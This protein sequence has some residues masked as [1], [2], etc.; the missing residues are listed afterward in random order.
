LLSLVSTLE[1]PIGRVELAWLN[2][3]RKEREG[4]VEVGV[5]LALVIVVAVGMEMPNDDDG[6]GVATP[7]PCRT[8]AAAPTSLERNLSGVKIFGVVVT[9]CR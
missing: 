5:P 7:V 2:S 8:V 4:G 6:K 3:E 1:W 9:I